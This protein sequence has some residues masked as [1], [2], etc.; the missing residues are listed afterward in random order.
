[1]RIIAGEL[2]GRRLKSPASNDVRPTSDKVKEA[3]FSMLIPYME[4]DFTAVDLFA[5]SGNMGL[6]AIS[7]GAERVYFTDASRQSLAL[8]KENIKICG[9]EERAVLICGDFRNNIRRINQEVDI[10]FLDPPY[11]DGFIPVALKAIDA[12]GNLRVGGVAVCEHAYKDKL[13]E[14]IPGFKLIKER[15]YGAIAV[16]IFEKTAKEIEEAENE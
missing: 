7:R 5:G 6:E 10:F 13:P 1:M 8:V 9:A 4:H 11:A 16:S 12:A 14:D 2:R 15:R 3:I